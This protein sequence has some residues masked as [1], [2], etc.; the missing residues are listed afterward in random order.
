MFKKKEKLKF[1]ALFIIAVASIFTVFNYN[2]KFIATDAGFD[3]DYDSGDSGGGWSSGGGS[4]WDYDSG[5]SSS[6]SNNR[7]INIISFILLIVYIILKEEARKKRRTKTLAPRLE[8][9]HN[10]EISEDE[11]NNY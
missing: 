5:S 3:T 7:I 6:S 9:N 10:K 1:V 8:L 2:P 4:D 11:F